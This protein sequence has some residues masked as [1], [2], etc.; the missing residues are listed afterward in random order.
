MRVQRIRHNLVTEQQQQQWHP[1]FLLM[2]FLHLTVFFNLGLWLPIGVLS[3]RGR[4]IGHIA[5]TMPIDALF[6][7]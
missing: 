3:G 4:V 6:K 2:T 5:Q 1:D 7:C